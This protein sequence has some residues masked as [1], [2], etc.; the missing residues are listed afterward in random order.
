MVQRVAVAEAKKTSGQRAAERG[1]HGH[2]STRL[3]QAA[4][5]VMLRMPSEYTAHDVEVML[6]ML[7]GMFSQSQSE[8][9]LVTVPWDDSDSPRKMTLNDLAGMLEGWLD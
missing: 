5:P 6:N 7:W 1:M 4:S 8:R 2:T 3:R 9:L